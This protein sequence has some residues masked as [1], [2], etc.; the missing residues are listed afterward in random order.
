MKP[1]SIRLSCV[2]L[3]LLTLFGMAHAAA[4]AWKLTLGEYRYA[5]YAGTDLNLR[6]QREAT[7]AWI[8]GYHDRVFGGQLRAGVDTALPLGD[9]LQLQ[10]S[11][12][13]ASQGFLGGSLTLQAGRSW[14]ALAGVG[15]TNLRPYFN[16]NF[17]PND[18]MTL[19]VGHRRDD[20]L[21]W[22]LFVVADDRLRTHQRDWHWLARVPWG[23]RRLTVDALYK[24]GLGDTGFVSG[25]GLGLTVDWPRWFLRAA[26]D[27]Y[28]NFGAFDAT[29]IAAG[30][31]F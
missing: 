23:T 12:Q 8:G 28:Q 26:R 10:P 31:R 1:L 24:S 6:W 11:L 13:A 5:E 20:G 7:H 19:G 22:S 17:D 21:E 14:Y 2:M 16:L 18:A 9:A 4:P 29:R 25:W 27:P 3:A 30:L 15:R